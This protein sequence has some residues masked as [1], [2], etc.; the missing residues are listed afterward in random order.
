MHWICR[1]LLVVHFHNIDSSSPGTW[2][3]SPSVYVIF[4]FFH[5]CLIIFHSSFVSLGR[6]F[7]PRYF[8]LFIAMLNGT[9]SLISL[10]VFSLLVCR[11]AS[12]FC[13]L[14]FYSETLLNSLTSLGNFLIVS[15]GFSKYS[16]MSSANSHLYFF[17][18]ST[19]KWY[20]I[21]VC[22][23]LSDFT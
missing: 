16:I 20:H 8:I 2:N 17:L 21:I 11:N 13:V 7:F 15:F 14:T 23:S 6:F 12:D 4:D 3:I 19:Y 18:D 1:L 22:L 9:D 10:S 5:Q